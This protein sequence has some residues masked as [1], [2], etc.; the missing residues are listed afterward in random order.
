M[1][2]LEVPVNCGSREVLL[3]EEAKRC[4]WTRET[5]IE[6]GIS[7]VIYLTHSL[8]RT[9][10]HYWRGRLEARRSITLVDIIFGE[11]SGHS[12]AVNSTVNTL[13]YG[14]VL[15]PKRLSLL[16]ACWLLLNANHLEGSLMVSWTLTYIHGHGQ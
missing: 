16:L 1:E 6:V 13:C 7:S 3:S 5:R 15:A 10:T 9:F 8:L 12:S 11:L 2:L 14:G 4:V